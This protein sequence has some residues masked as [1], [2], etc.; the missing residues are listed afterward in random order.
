[1]HR[2][3]LIEWIAV[4]INFILPENVLKKENPSYNMSESKSLRDQR[5]EE[6]HLKS[7]IYFRQFY[8]RK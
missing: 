3:K 2:Q 1:M 5:C 4:Q 8:C 6:A 7:K